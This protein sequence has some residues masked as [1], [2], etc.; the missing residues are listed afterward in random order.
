MEKQQV[1]GEYQKG[2]VRFDMPSFRER[3]QTQL[4]GERSDCLS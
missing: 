1:I 4:E 3:L 2:Y